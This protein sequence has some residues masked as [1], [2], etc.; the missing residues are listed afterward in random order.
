[1]ENNKIVYCEFAFLKEF[2]RE[3]INRSQGLCQSR[4]E[5]DSVWDIMYLLY[6]SELCLDIPREKLGEEIKDDPILKKLGKSHP[7]RSSLDFPNL[8]IINDN[9]DLNFL[10]SIFMTVKNR[11]ER[12]E[13]SSKFGIIVIGKEDILNFHEVYR[14][15]DIPISKGEESCW[16]K[17]SFSN[18]CI[19][20]AIIIEDNYLLSGNDTKRIK[21]NL[22]PL[23]DILLPYATI[24]QYHISIYTCEIFGNEK[25]TCKL[26]KDEITQIRPALEFKLCVYKIRKDSQGRFH[27]RNIFTNNLHL[28]CS[29]G[30]DLF[31]DKG[32]ATKTTTIRYAYPYFIV[33][34]EGNSSKKNIYLNY[35]HD[36]IEI[37]ALDHCY[38]I[39]YWGE[40]SRQNRLIDYIKGEKEEE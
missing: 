16:G 1:M 24:V 25:A 32:S 35:I 27:D 33:D 28:D 30:F 40:E 10:N 5:L 26:I 19:S 21:N 17:I 31:D 38:N 23:L 6:N 18:L 34:K 14:P 37:E 7:I 20:N 4:E 12:K 2:S 3:C 13:L 22:V 8:N 11:R 29:G 15:N 9:V 36:I 39:D